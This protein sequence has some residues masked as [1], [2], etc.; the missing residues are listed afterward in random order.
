MLQRAGR[1]VVWRAG[2]G[3]S[4]QPFIRNAYAIIVVVCVIVVDILCFGF[5]YGNLTSG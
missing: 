2:F 3:L 5:C 1:P 4:I